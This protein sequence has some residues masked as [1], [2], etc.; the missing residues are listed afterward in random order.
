M[1]PIQRW[2]VLLSG[3]PVTVQLA[4]SAVDEHGHEHELS[5]LFSYGNESRPVAILGSNAE[6]RAVA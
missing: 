1:L 6:L 2:K 4:I 3:L 5:S